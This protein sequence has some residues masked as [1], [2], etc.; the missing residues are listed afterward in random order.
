MGIIDVSRLRLESGEKHSV[1]VLIMV[2]EI[3]LG[4]VSYAGPV[5]PVLASV[6]ITRLQ[7]GLLLDLRVTAAITGPC[8]RCLE[9][10]AISVSIDAS[11]YQ[12]DQPDRD[13]L[14]EEVC[15]YLTDGRLDAAVWAGD[16]IVL[17]LPHKILCRADCMGLCP[18]CGTNLNDELCQCGPPEPDGRWGPLRGLAAGDD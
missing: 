18:A 7:T 13:A 4:G 8:H 9:P 12:A 3:L 10:A 15:D 17:A 1:E 16:A 11:E 14:A 5:V 6:E 2:S